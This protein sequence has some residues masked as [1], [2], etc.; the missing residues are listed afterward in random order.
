M[1]TVPSDDA[2]REVLVVLLMCP[3]TVEQ[4]VTML[5]EDVEKGLAGRDGS[6]RAGVGRV[7][8][9]LHRD[10]L[11]RPVRPAHDSWELTGAGR[12]VAQRIDDAS[13]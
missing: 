11:I 5:P 6:V 12:T 3:E 10:G 4:L 1:S 9:A 13:G 2:A 8:G 7:L